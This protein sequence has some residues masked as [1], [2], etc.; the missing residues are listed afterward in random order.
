MLSSVLEHRHIIFLLE[1]HF[2]IQVD[3]IALWVYNTG[4]LAVHGEWP[5][6]HSIVNGLAC[7]VHT[8]RTTN[9]G[10]AVLFWLRWPDTTMRV[11]QWKRLF[12]IASFILICLLATP[13][14]ALTSDIA[15]HSRLLDAILT[16]QGKILVYIVSCGKSFAEK[17]LI[18]VT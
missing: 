18:Y 9:I 3:Y 7:T 15:P 11:L 10:S 17:R 16:I 2:H 14:T 13:L 12:R 5:F 8:T 4:A 1:R 6:C